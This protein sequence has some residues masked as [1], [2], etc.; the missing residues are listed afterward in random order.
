M[1]AMKALI[2]GLALTIVAAAG[3]AA[4]PLPDETGFVA[5]EVPLIE[6]GKPDPRDSAVTGYLFTPA[7]AGPFPA[8]VIMHGC[9]GLGWL[10]PARSS[11]TL[12]KSDAQRYVA[13]GYV[14]LVLDSFEPRRIAQACGAPMTVSPTRRAW[15]A[16]S[17]ARYLGTRADIDLRHLV[18]QGDSHGG[19][20][21]LW[22]LRQGASSPS[23]FAAGIAFYP[24]LHRGERLHR[25]HSHP[26]RRQGRCRRF[27]ASR[28][29]IRS[30]ARDIT[31]S[32]SRYIP[33]P[34]TPSTFRCGLTPTRWAI[35]SPMTPRPRRRAGRRS[36]PSCFR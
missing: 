1:P 27:A 32:S 6:H 35:S 22:T 3:A 28:W 34:P 11:W 29:C 14:A 13:H 8:V 21:V 10:R 5:V 19:L 31:R 15:D 16:L 26:H 4:R 12:F 7:G 23:P 24:R 36:M 25:A 33:A 2:F 17:A 30:R 20:R 18:L 9:D